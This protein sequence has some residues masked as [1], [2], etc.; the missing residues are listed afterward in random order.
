[1]WTNA[2]R[3]PLETVH[4]GDAATIVSPGDDQVRASRQ[5]VFRQSPT[6]AIALP[7]NTGALFRCDTAIQNDLDLVVIPEAF[8]EEV[9]HLA[10]LPRNDKQVPRPRQENGL[11]TRVCAY[12]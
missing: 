9:I 8:D 12:F 4:A 7:G 10:V 6:A 1:M 11:V 5:V 2:R 3:S